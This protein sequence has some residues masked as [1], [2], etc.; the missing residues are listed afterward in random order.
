MGALWVQWKNRVR[1]ASDRPSG[2]TSVV[3]DCCVDGVGDGDDIQIQPQ[4]LGKIQ[5][6]A[7]GIHFAG[8]GRRGTG[9]CEFGIGEERRA[10]GFFA[11][12]AY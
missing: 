6:M 12:C 8:G 7:V 4:V 2:R 9:W 1:S 10:E 5:N 11:S 3:G